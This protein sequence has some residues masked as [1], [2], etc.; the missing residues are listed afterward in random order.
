MPTDTRTFSDGRRTL[1]LW[2][3]LL[4]ASAILI[5]PTVLAAPAQQPSGLVVIE[6]LACGILLGIGRQG[7]DFLAIRLLIAAFVLLLGWVVGGNLRQHAAV[8]GSVSDCQHLAL[9]IVFGAILVV[10][11]LAVVAV[12]A[13]IVWNRGLAAL[14][15]EL[16]W[17]RLPRPRTWWQWILLAVAVVV[18]ISLLPILFAI[19][20]Y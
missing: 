15:P 18:V 9:G 4:L 5:V 6:A 3:A 11:L 14:R 2:A 17:K 8:C 7:I 20:I 1:Q 16:D 12:P 13:T 19:P 10:P